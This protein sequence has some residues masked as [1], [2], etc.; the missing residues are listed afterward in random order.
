MHRIL[1]LGIVFLFVFCSLFV[2]AGP[3]SIANK[4]RV[5]A[6]SEMAEKGKAANV[7]DGMI[8]TNGKGEWVSKSTVTFWGHI[9]YPWIQLD[10]EKPQSINKI[11][12]Y[13]RATETAH[14]AGGVLI[15]SNGTRI[16]VF[17]I[18]NNGAPKIVAFPE[19]T[20]TSVRFETTDADGPAI[21]LSEIE[22][23]PSPSQISDPVSW[24]DP[25][26]ESA[27]GRYFFFVTGSQ[28][29]GMISAAPL[30]RNKNQ[31]G[32]GYNYNST[33]VLGFPQVHCWMLSG[34]TLMPTTGAVDP[35][36]GEQQWK[37]KFSHEAEIVQP[38]YHRL[39][40]DNYNTWVEQTAGDRVSFYRFTYT[41]DVRSNILINLGGYVG[42]ATMNDAR[43]QKVS[44][45]RI[46]GS[47][48]TTG[49]LWGGPEN[50][51]I[52]FA[53]D[54]EKPFEKLN[55]WDGK[56]ELLDVKSLTGS[57][58][59]TAKNSGRM[60]YYDA[61]TTG[62]SAQYHVKAGETVQ[63]KVAV[64]FTS[65][66]NAR[67]NLESE[68]RHWD[69]DQLREQSQKEWNEMLGRIAVKGGSAN[70]K[71]KFYT[72]LW[73]ALLGRHKLDD[74]SGDYPDNTEG[75]RRGSFTVNTKFKIRTLPKDQN[76]KVKFHM[77]NSDAFWL[78]QWNLNVLWG[79]AWPEVLD[80]FAAS[81]IQY[82]ENG[83]L[84]P[85]GPC[86]GGYSYIMTGCPATNLI[87]CA[88][89]KGILTKK[90][91]AT[92]YEVMK[93][94]HAP[95]GMMGDK[96]PMEF[97]I[98]NGYYP[99]NAGITLEI[100]F[101]DWALAQ[102][103][104]KLGKKKDAE[105][106]TKRSQGWTKLF[107]Q[108]QKLIFPKTKEGTW[109]HKNPLDGNGWVEA[110][111][112]QATWSVS[113]GIDQLAQ[114]MGGTDT[115]C[116]ML[117]YAFEKA[118]SQ[119]FVFGYSSG[120]VSY[121]NQPG[122]SNAH[123]F[124]YAGRPDLTQ[125][126]VRRVNEQAYGAVTPDKGYGGHDEDQGQMSGVSALTSIGLFSLNGNCSINPVYDITSPVFDEVVIKLNKDYYSGNE[127]VIKTNNNSKANCY[128][129]KASL[130]GKDHNQFSFS[131]AD[132][133]KGGLLELWLGAQPNLSW[134]K[135]PAPSQSKKMF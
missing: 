112:W 26:I 14:N 11:I 73:H 2:Y 95:G 38:G 27:R 21:G 87:T 120:Y 36:K 44:D 77:Y 82:A 47:V 22:V 67:R 116:K 40:L 76:G 94:N 133:S 56:Q 35:N 9:D 123:V 101:Q 128:I 100:A 46:E 115:L 127:F 90:P 54:F 49:R 64:S 91:V 60:S 59:K 6:S 31:Y 68:C 58:E 50:V 20:V 117:N 37:S 25:Y 134:G 5:T 71:I 131:H 97:Y 135:A 51:R 104:Y 75:E 43:V 118:Q 126:W 130:N 3:G 12:L 84:L 52:Y 45:T 103:A 108:D 105:Y 122:C 57:P 17:E 66:D 79:L 111:A 69:F 23:Y 92:A 39:Y 4:A 19:Q 80:D 107:D 98:K 63:M 124:N 13:D 93:Q 129:Q 86:A 48:N 18:P 32:G 55:G 34:I 65:V 10:W 8:R 121:A 110:N 78:T 81:L 74:V 132:F 62:V 42:E 106:F 96:E 33:E 29:F 125:Y 88:Y 89:Q 41:K 70:Q 102:M 85:R 109:A 53:I 16:P 28:P 119:D 99:S 15:F 61:P 83:K 7:I 1:S 30:T 114:M 113:H 24:V 72:D